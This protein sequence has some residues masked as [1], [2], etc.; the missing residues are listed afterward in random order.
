MT[1]FEIKCENC[2]KKITTIMVFCSKVIYYIE[3]TKIEKKYTIY[4]SYTEY[5]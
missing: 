3:R 4:Y 2:L 1:L 5:I